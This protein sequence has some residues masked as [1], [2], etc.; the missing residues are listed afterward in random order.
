MADSSPP[1]SVRPATPDDELAV[2]RILDGAMLEFAALT[3]RIDADDVLV[4][5]EARFEPS[6]NRENPS[7]ETA[8]EASDDESIQGAIVL[9]PEPTATV[10]EGLAS[11]DEA[12]TQSAAAEPGAH[13]DAIAV[14]MRR[15][16]RGIGATLVER[17]LSREGRLTA[18]FDQRVRPFYEALDFEIVSLDDGRFAGVRRR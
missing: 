11:N 1:I 3:P 4:A 14:R 10:T 18:H 7:G 13:V 16:G 6:E 9:E 15:R 2:R 5:S 12:W 17:A 8:S